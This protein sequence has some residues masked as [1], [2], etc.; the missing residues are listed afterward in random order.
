VEG[1]FEMYEDSHLRRDCEEFK[2]GV[3]GPT[4]SGDE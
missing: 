3:R 4:L 2:S 1:K